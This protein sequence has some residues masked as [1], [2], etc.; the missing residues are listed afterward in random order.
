M[1]KPFEL[2]NGR[3]RDGSKAPRIQPHFSPLIMHLASSTVAACQNQT[4]RWF[5]SR[6]MTSALKWWFQVAFIVNAFLGLY[7]E[8]VFTNLF[9]TFSNYVSFCVCDV[10]LSHPLLW[11]S[12]LVVKWLLSRLGVLSL[13]FSS[14]L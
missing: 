7:W 1:D 5:Y 9:L 10:L 14:R 8:L 4:R 13:L 2:P 11:A 3:G 6:N 12:G